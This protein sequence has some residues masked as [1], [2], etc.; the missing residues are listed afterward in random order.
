MPGSPIKNV[1]NRIVRDAILRGLKEGQDPAEFLEPFAGKLKE[2][3][4]AGDMSAMK[5]LFD[6]I[7]GKA[8][9]QVLVGGDGEEPI[10]QT[11]EQVIVDAKE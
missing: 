1:R 4:L 8:A 6:R 11:I 5:E 7:E 10:R 2:L 3:A 9:Q